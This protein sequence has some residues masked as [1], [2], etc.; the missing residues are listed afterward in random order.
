MPSFVIG[1]SRLAE[2]ES[3][4]DGLMGAVSSSAEFKNRLQLMKSES[5]E[6]AVP[7]IR[8][9]VLDAMLA[10]AFNRHFDSTPA[11]LAYRDRL[12]AGFHLSSLTHTH[13]GALALICAIQESARVALNSNPRQAL[14]AAVHHCSHI[15]LPAHLDEPTTEELPR[16]D[17]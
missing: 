14:D 15:L 17:R 11:M 6:L 12:S 5:P 3:A 16:L 13:K 7:Q 8:Q 9:R 10:G 2:L 4:Y 1:A